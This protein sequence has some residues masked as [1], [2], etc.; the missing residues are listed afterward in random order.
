MALRFTRRI[1]VIPGVR[2]NL[3]KRGASLGFGQRG[4]WL[5]IGAKGV[6]TSVGLPGSGL[7]WTEQ[8]AWWNRQGGGALTF[9]VRLLAFALGAAI[10]LAVLALIVAA[11]G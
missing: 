4:A 2:I 6:H 9:V 10:G 5:T 3:G 1:G 7:Y 11:Y 8:T